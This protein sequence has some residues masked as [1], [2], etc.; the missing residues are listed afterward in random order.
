MYV[1]S[2]F[3]KERIA[4]EKYVAV[5]ISLYETLFCRLLCIQVCPC[6]SCSYLKG[7]IDMEMVLDFL[8]CM[9]NCNTSDKINC[10]IPENF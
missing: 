1:H 4:L 8:L 9:L 10:N 5:Y 3:C 6:Y 7:I 2:H